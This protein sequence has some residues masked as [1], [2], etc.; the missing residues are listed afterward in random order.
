MGKDYYQILGVAKDA[1]DDVIKKA[2]R[3]LAVKYHPDKNPDDAAAASEKFKEVA[4][5][6]DVLSDP[7]KRAVFDAYGEEGL[8]GGVPPE[9]GMGGA[10]GMG[11]M[12]GAAGGAGPGF[13]YSGVD[14]EAA[15]HI[16]ESLFGG[17]GGGLGGLFGGMGGGGGGAP[18]GAPRRRAHVFSSGPRGAASMFGP[19][20]GYGRESPGTPPSPGVM[21]GM[22]ESDDEG[23]W[24]HGGF[25]S[26]VDGQG[27]PMGRGGGGAPAGPDVQQVALKLTLEDLYKGCT[28]KLKV[29]RA[30]FDGASGKSTPLSE[31]V[32][33]CVR[34]GW[35]KGTKITF[36]GKGDEKPGRPPADLQFVV[37]EAPHARFKREGNDLHATVRV[38][39]VSALCGGAAALE[40]LDGR[41]LDFPIP[42]MTSGS[43]TKVLP[44][45]GM[46]ISK[47]PGK[48]G[49]LIVTV[50]AAFPKALTAAQKEQLRGILPA[51]L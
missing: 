24:G 44:G 9:G 8:K 34:P 22:S 12:G 6:Y 43:T 50:E 5:A 47:E 39:L 2:Y 10:G 15:Q 20:S 40:S 1:G 21:F 27:G 37:D 16:F 32:E 30:V 17:G 31:V 3:K 38:P 41:K 51:A 19:S 29:T 35:K 13:R 26:F 33:V 49:N 14:P 18:G 28:K 25:G 7:Q 4:E 36:P 48:R 46:P 45:E 11:G 23:A 42:V